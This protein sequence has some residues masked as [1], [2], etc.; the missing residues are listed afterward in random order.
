MSPLPRVYVDSMAPHTTFGLSRF[1][2]DM[3]VPL[4]IGGDCV[5]F[6]DEPFPDILAVAGNDPDRSPEFVIVLDGNVNT[7]APDLLN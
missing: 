6:P 7:F 5:P 4:A 2:L 3:F 1:T